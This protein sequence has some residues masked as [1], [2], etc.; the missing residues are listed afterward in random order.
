MSE[1]IKELF[2]RIAPKY[3]L[4]NGLLSLSIDRYWRREA[5]SHLTTPSF[6]KVLDLCA[7]TLSMTLELL[8]QNPM[9]QIEALDFSESMLQEGKKRIPPLLKN[10]IGLFCG[11]SLAL[12]FVNGTFDGAM[13][14]YGL[15]NVDDNRKALLELHRVLRPKGKLVILEFFRPDRF[16]TRLF[17]STYGRFFIPALGRL[18]SRHPSAYSYLKNSV[19]KFYSTTEYSRLLTDCSF[20]KI[21]VHRQT[22]G[23][24]TLLIAEKQ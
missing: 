9:A 23:V 18:V 8:K 22:G 3:D 24:S 6:K 1:E 14:A 19:K 10:Q 15:R 20:E 12:P 11:D 17:H 4:L 16:A 2:S 5:V 7:G 21:E 13:C